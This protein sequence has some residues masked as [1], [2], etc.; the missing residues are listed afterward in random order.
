MGVRLMAV[1]CLALTMSGC[2]IPVTPS[3]LQSQPS[4][5]SAN[6]PASWPGSLIYHRDGDPVDVRFDNNN[7]HWDMT[8]E[9]HSSISDAGRKPWGPSAGLCSMGELVHILDVSLARFQSDRPNAHLRSMVLQMHVSRRLWSEILSGIRK[10]E[11]G[12]SGRVETNSFAVQSKVDSVLHNSPTVAGITRELKR[13]G[14][15]VTGVS[16][17]T[18]LV[19]EGERTG[20]KWS[21]NAALADGG[22]KYPGLV[23]F[24]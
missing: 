18:F 20:R 13:H 17:V 11:A 8:V 3:H 10:G 12:M 21:Q 24:D 4:V 2:L 22:L 14:L 5:V 16:S 15:K 9:D 23:E 6:R 19:F 7:G 1:I